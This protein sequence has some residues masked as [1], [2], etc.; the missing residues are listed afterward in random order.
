MELDVGRGRPGQ[1][2]A[3]VH[4]E[5]RSDPSD[6][7]SDTAMAFQG[8]EE[9]VA[10]E[11][12]AVARER[13][14]LRRRHVGDAPD[15]GDGVAGGGGSVVLDG[16][17]GGFGDGAFA[18]PARGVRIGRVHCHRAISPPVTDPR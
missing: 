12:V 10:G 2:A 16:G 13:V 18:R 6:P 5:V 3:G 7:F 11:G 15:G 14:P 8:V 9:G 1:L 17:G 4:E